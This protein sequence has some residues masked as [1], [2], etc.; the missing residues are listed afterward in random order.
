[1][2]SASYFLLYR[3]QE[4]SLLPG[5]DYVIG[6]SDADIVLP[7]GLVSRS[8]AEIRWQGGEF[9]L[10]DN[11]STNG[12]Q[13]NGRSVGNH[14]LHDGD[15][16]KIGCFDLEFV[17]GER[18]G[19]GEADFTLFPSETIQLERRLSSF[20]D[21]IEDPSVINGFYALKQ[22]YDRKKE[23]L[24]N[25]AYKDTLTG[26]YNRRFFEEQAKT[27]AARCLRYQRPLQL[28]ML[29][30]DHFK[31]INDTH[32]H[33][34]GDEVL[35]TISQVLLDGCRGADIAVRYG[36]EEL[37]M[38]LPET[39]SQEAFLV[40]E[41]IRE[42]IQRETLDQTGVG[43]T[44]SIGV[45]SFNEANSSIDLLLASADRLLY[46]GKMQGRNMTMID[47]AYMKPDL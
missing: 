7:H 31:Q 15:R 22:L 17:I 29:D 14:I 21:E 25:F 27:E 1:M 41:K 16:I 36:G 44:V 28:A 34:K 40:A 37:L 43:A 5:H 2:N 39:D 42:A 35:K 3:N 6:R 23:K 20:I 24:Q 9:C 47:A 30:V 38:L 18:V 12:T 10:V 32:G 8:H 19:A 4:L 46:A 45:A 33:L 11:R 13:V 26:L